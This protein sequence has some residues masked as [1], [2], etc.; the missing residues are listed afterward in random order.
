MYID[1]KRYN[2]F[3]KPTEVKDMQYS[4]LFVAYAIQDDINDQGLY[5]QSVRNGIDPPP[6]PVDLRIYPTVFNEILTRPD[7]NYAENCADGT[8][9]ITQD[10]RN[11][12][13]FILHRRINIL[14]FKIPISPYTVKFK[15]DSHMNIDSMY[16]LLERFEIPFVENG[17]IEMII[18]K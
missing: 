12:A 18:K 13:T 7:R 5:Y 17:E 4:P 6:Y 15:S 2:P 9:F 10:R 11:P 16:I 3:V 1:F 14:G 8:Y